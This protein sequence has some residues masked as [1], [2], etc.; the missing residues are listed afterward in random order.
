M[1]K[2]KS[3]AKKIVWNVKGGYKP[4][5]FW[6][7]WANDFIKDAWQRKIHS[8]HAW[9]IKKIKKDRP[10]K[11]LEVGCGFG[12]NIK[13]LIENEIKAEKIEGS[14]I[15]QKMIK[16][17]KKYV[18]DKR[19]KF[20]VAEVSELPYKDKEFELVLVHGVFMHVKPKNIEN[21]IKEVLRVSSGYVLIFEQNYNGNEY[22][23]V[24]DYEGLLKT[25]KGKIIDKKIDKKTGLSY[26]YVKVLQKHK[27]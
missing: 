17:A 18:N 13:F 27:V 16:F 12:R 2:F 24:H 20:R 10:K 7:N 9:M 21:A 14:D 5:K 25:S 6:D 11:I 22:T 15:S 19:V 3:V 4:K 26:Y 8:Q 1:H 23:F